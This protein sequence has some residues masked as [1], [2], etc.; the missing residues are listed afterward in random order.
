MTRIS[1]DRTPRRLRAIISVDF[2]ATAI[3]AGLVTREGE[4]LD[5][6]QEATHERATNG[7]AQ[8]LDAIRNLQARA[9][10]RKIRVEGVGVGLPGIVD[11]EKGMMTGEGGNSVPEFSRVPIIDRIREATG[12]RAFADN[13]VN[14][15]ALAEHRYGAGR[16][17]HSLV[18][19]ALGT[20]PGGAVILDG[21]LVRGRDGYAGEFGHLP[22][23]LDGPVCP[24][25]G[26]GCTSYY[27]AGMMIARRARASLP[28]H[29][30]SKLL[31][32]AGGDPEAISARLVFDAARAGDDLSIA[33]VDQA[34][35]ALG[36]G[37]GI[38]LNGLNPD[39]VVITGGM[40]ASLLEREADILRRAGKYAFPRV[41]AS[42]T[43][44]IVPSSKRDT[45]RGG[46]A[47]FLYESE[48]RRASRAG[49]ARARK[50]G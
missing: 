29:P 30:G 1:T 38:I 33:L 17:V 26:H 47:L 5:V 19:V 2:G 49:S 7:V 20:G 32:M 42:T 45:V 16:G 39:L 18:L 31:A 11:V 10:Q 15:L 12:L 13:D 44:R 40:A 27:L 48:L 14:A 43:I 41:L 9:R 22:V 37:L 6:V 46:A 50:R 36:A 25:G 8:L 4:I 28:V 34:C 35:E 3:S 21:K 23:V 24:C